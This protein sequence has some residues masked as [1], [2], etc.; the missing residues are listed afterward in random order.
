MSMMSSASGG[1]VGL[2]AHTAEP[3][4][5]ALE[6]PAEPT[7]VVHAAPMPA[8]RDEDAIPAIS[9]GG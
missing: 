3:E 7:V 5:G 8:A 4:L 1:I 9:L 6:A 2:E